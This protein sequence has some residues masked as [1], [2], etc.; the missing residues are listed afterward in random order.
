MAWD[1]DEFNSALDIWIDTTERGSG[2]SRGTQ[3]KDRDH[4]DTYI[5]IVEFPSYEQAMRNSKRPETSE[6]ADTL[7][8][9]CD[10]PPV[11]RN[12]D[13]LQEREM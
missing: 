9:L 6:L 12:L 7:A 8:K 1:L 5:Q 2:P 3:T 4:D 11:F 13:V 10:G